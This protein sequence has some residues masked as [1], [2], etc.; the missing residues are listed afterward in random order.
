MARRWKSGSG[1]IVIWNGH[2][3]TLPFD[4]PLGYADRVL[5]S[6]TFN[7]SRI[8]DKKTVNCTFPRADGGAER[9]G[10]IPLFAHG[11]S[12][13]PRVRGNFVLNGKTISLGCHV[14]VQFYTSTNGAAIRSLIRLAILGATN[15][16][17]VVSWYAGLNGLFSGGY[18]AEF[19]VPM[20]IEVFDEM[21][22]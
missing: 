22:E 18:L 9:S 2:T 1:K 16:D 10:T 17:V 13:Q 5:F 21:N 11:R 3:D 8:V 6:T 19:T 4:D 7:Y 12:G 20:T 15:T 14:P